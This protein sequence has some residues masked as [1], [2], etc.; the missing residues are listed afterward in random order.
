MGKALGDRK[1]AKT[2]SLKGSTIIMLEEIN[3]QMI[4]ENHSSI[5]EKLIE[6]KHKSVCGKPND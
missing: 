4:N 1:M 3:A 6:D 2:I 5:I